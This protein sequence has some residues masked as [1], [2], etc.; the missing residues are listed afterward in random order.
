MGTA[1]VQ[2]WH[3]SKPVITFVFKVLC[4]GLLPYIL[5]TCPNSENIRVQSATLW[6]ASVHTLHMSKP[7]IR[8]VIQSAM[9]WTAPVHT[10]HMSKPV[11]AFVFKVVRNGLLRYIL[12]TCPYL[13][14]RSSSKCYAMDCFRTYFTHV[15]TC[16]NI[17]VQ[18]ATQWTASVHTFHMSKR[19]ITF[20]LKVLLNGFFGTYF[21]HVRTCENVRVQSAMQWTAPVHT[22]HM[23]KSVST[24]VFKVLLNGLLRYILDTCPSLWQ[25]LC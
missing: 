22:L 17:C 7:V 6:T 8:F 11:R 20:V 10:L 18:S 5:Y 16:E 9:Q 19:L 4:N 3:A 23:S 24:F 21:T 14:E 13:W 2:S 15:Q 25:P 1:S 12:Y